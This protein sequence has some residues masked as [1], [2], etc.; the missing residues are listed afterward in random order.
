MATNLAPPESS[1][2]RLAR[3]R[4]RALPN[5]R[6]V[7]TTP[8][9]EV[10]HM[11]TSADPPAD[12]PPPPAE[13]EFHPAAAL[14]PLMPVDSPE[15]GELVDDIG[16][17]GLLQPIILHE[18]GILDGRNRYRACQH[19]GVE[20]RFEEWRGE[21]P[22]AYVLSLNLHR[23]HLTEDQK[24]AIVQNARARLEAEGKERMAAGGRRS[25][26][27]RPAGKGMA[28]SPDL[29]VTAPTTR[30]RLADLAN[31]S[32]HRIRQAERVQKADPELNQHVIAGD[33]PLTVAAT[34]VDLRSALDRYPFIREACNL[35]P[36]AAIEM[37]R[38]LDKA[39][40]ERRPQM[41]EQARRWCQVQAEL[42][43][44]RQAAQE[45]LEAA[46]AVSHLAKFNTLVSRFGVEM[47]AQSLIEA[48]SPGR[49]NGI[50]ILRMAAAAV[51]DLRRLT[52]ASPIRRVK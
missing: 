37:A 48:P 51:A 40:E 22:T 28:E 43:P 14:F 47:V 30:K 31:V 32:E 27:G 45:Q 44:K 11:R 33:V 42:A 9:D 23:R 4:R 41:L 35:P 25:A 6:R 19:A 8:V 18:G 1:Y 46:A 13:L 2:N 17:H 10:P 21:S 34:E 49:E 12:Q 7:T 29:S 5:R 3:A 20:P 52:D 36:G 39:P 50:E 15:F 16:E 26:P 24:A 38:S